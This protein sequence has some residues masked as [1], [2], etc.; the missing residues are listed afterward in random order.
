MPPLGFE[1]AKSRAERFARDREK[2]RHLLEEAIF[3]AG[4]HKDSLRKIWDELSVFFRLLKSWINGQYKDV[5]WQ[6]IVLII[7]AVIYFVAPIDAIIDPL[8]FVGYID[9]VTVIAFV[10]ASVK[11]DIERF[12]EWEKAGGQ[13]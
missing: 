6:S 13:G 12:L 10:I 7:A 8:P 5:S 11:K 2:V 4:R 1:R 3:K 9:D